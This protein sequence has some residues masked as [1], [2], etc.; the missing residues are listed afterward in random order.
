[1]RARDFRATLLRRLKVRSYF[2]LSLR[3]YSSFFVFFF[4]SLFSIPIPFHVSFFYM[5]FLFNFQYS[6]RN[7][8]TEEIR[9]A[10]LDE[11]A[12]REIKDYY[13]NSEPPKVR[14]TSTEYKLSVKLDKGSVFYTF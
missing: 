9:S 6:H 10:F 13:N 11:R 12:K 8:S 14:V 2:F 4:F 3:G 7:K 1:M 5:Y